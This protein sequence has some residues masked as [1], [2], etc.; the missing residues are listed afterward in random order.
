MYLPWIILAGVG[1]YACLPAKK[2]KTL[3]R[4]VKKAVRD[5]RKNALD[6]LDDDE[7]CSHSRRSKKKPVEA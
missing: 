2:K 1:G 4:V 5:M 6:T 7:P 3:K